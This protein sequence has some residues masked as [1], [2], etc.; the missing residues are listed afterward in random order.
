MDIYCPA[1]Q[2]KLQIADTYAGQ[3]VKCSSCAASFQAPALPSMGPLPTL[4]P[5]P[6]APSVTFGMAPETPRP[7][8]DLPPPA[9]L[10]PLA[11]KPRP[12]GDYTH[13]LTINLRQDIITLIPPLGLLLLF[14]LSFFPWRLVIGASSL[15]LWE[16]AFSDK[17]ATGMLW[18]VLLIILGS[19]F[20]LVTPFLNKNLLPT[21]PALRPYLPWSPAVIVIF[22]VAAWF[23]FMIHYFHCTFL[24]PIDPAALAMKVAFRLHTLMVLAAM[25]DWWLAPPRAQDSPGTHDQDALVGR[26][27]S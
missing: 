12:K 26:L 23:F 16:L 7:A 24:E 4:E 25:T 19:P 13:S 2:K 14:F 17:G 5:P 27:P 1:C 9:P 10:P 20:I 6:A 15:N 18:F 21:P 8:P 3:M 22:S 11:Q